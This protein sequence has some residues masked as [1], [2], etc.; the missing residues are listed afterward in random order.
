M[1]IEGLRAVTLLRV[2]TEKQTNKEDKDIPAQRDI[3]NEFIK[4]EKL[5]FIKEFVEGGVSGFKTKLEDRDKLIEIKRM[6]KNKLF[7]ILVVYKSDRIGRTTDES[8]LVI[9]YLNDNGI[10]VF[11]TSDG[12]IKS[13]T[14]MDKLL[15]YIM[16]WQNETESVKLA[17]RATDYQAQM[18]KNGQ[19]RGGGKKSIPYGYKL[20]NNGSVNKKG[21]NIYD[22]I[23]DEERANIIKLIFELS[24]KQNM[25]ARAIAAYLNENGYKDKATSLNGWSFRT[26][27]DIFNNI[28]YKGYLHMK[29]KLKNE[30]IISP[31]QEHLVIIPEDE[32]DLNQQ[33]VKSRITIN[34]DGKEGVPI[35]SSTKGTSLLCG[36]VYCGYCGYKMHLWNNYKT[37]INKDGTKRKYIVSNYKCQSRLTKKTI[38]CE[39]QGT[40]STKKIDFIAEGI[41][42]KFINNFVKDNASENILKDIKEDLNKT[43]E[44]IKLKERELKEKEK[45][46]I[47]LKKEIAKSL[48][49]QGKF[50]PDM[51]SEAIKMTQEDALNLEIDLKKLQEQKNQQ[52]K[53]MSNYSNIEDYYNNWINK[54][55]EASIENKRLLINSIVEKVIIYKDNIEISFRLTGETYEKYTSFYG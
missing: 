54:Y 29:S 26:V 48:S 10:R 38:D 25:G 45:E 53:N 22:F 41:I 40:Y 30:T 28:T 9:K 12:E 11:T 4:K 21:R 7:D 39:G 51:L 19:Y 18:V 37:Y 5:L 34:S 43:T 24:I 27:G 50:T 6:A 36:L 49:G 1:D 42:L 15:T 31:K 3:V 32:W 20:V 17:E 52:Y 44:R 16:F 2:S 33:K 13:S 14:Q 8:P 46:I 47:T 35:K 55:Q 23:I